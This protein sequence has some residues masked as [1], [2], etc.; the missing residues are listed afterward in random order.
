MGSI[1]TPPPPI[2]TAAVLGATAGVTAGAVGS[3]GFMHTE[4]APSLNST[5]AGS[6]LYFS[7]V[8]NG[9]SGSPPAGTWRCFGN[10]GGAGGQSTLFVRIS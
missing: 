2:T 3:Y 4:Y 5:I 10:Y 1:Y 7:T 9:G 8:P 6:S